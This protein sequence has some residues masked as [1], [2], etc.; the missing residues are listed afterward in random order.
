MSYTMVYYATRVR[1]GRVVP[2]EVCCSLFRF[3]TAR[4][5]ADTGHELCE[6][7]TADP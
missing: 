2:E 5:A 1:K 3:G 6:L 7:T 4:T